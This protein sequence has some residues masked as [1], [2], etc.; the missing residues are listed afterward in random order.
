MYLMKTMVKLSDESQ[1]S[2]FRTFLERLMN[3]QHQ[4]QK[5]YQT[6]RYLRDRLMSSIDIPHIQDA[7]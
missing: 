7:L 2:A 1:M 3:L 5:D 6:E 4:V